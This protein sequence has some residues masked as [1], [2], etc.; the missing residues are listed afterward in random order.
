[1]TDLPQKPPASP[2][3]KILLKIIEGYL[4]LEEYRFH[5]LTEECIE[6]YLQGTNLT[7]RVLVYFHNRHL[8]VRIPAFI[9]NV[10][11]RRMEVLTHLMDIM[12]DYFDI[13]FEMGPD[14]RTL[15]ASSNHIIEDGELTQKQFTQCLMVVAY[16]VDEHFPKLM[17]VIYG[18]KGKT[19]ESATVAS[20]EPEQPVTEEESRSPG[21]N[22]EG[23]PD[24]STNPDQ[25]K[26]LN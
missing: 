25:P 21:E 2:R 17:Q 23:E 3:E 8:I 18:D 24:D 14:G 13:R 11:L 6:L 12:N 7:M 9:R 16:L 15:S 22:D 1:M 10:D 20:N 4:K 19:P 5:F 26:K